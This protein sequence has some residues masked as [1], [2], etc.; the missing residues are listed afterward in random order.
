MSA[1]LHKVGRWCAEHA[2]RVVAAW[3][4]LIAALAGV[5]ALTGANLS[6]TFTINNAESM[7][8]LEVLENRLPQAAGTSEQVLFTAK[9]GDIEAHRQAIEGFVSAVSAMDGVAMVSQPF[10]SAAD[11]ASGTPASPSTVSQDGAHALA[12]IQA[13]TSL[14]S[15]TSGTTSAAQRLDAQIEEAKAAAQKA[16]PQLRIQDSGSIGASVSLG[17]SVVELIGVVIAAIVLFITFGSVLAAGAPLI[18]A[19]IGVAAGMLGIFVVAN[20]VDVNST[21]PVLAVMI[22]LAVGIDYA[23]F[24]ISRAREY[25]AQGLSPAEAAGCATATAGSAVVFAGTTVVIALCGLAVARIPF[26]TVMGVASAFVV[27]CAVLV[28]LTVVPALI[29]ALGRRLQ[30]DARRARCQRERQ[31]S[32]RPTFAQRW[33]RGVTRHPWLTVSAVLA[34]L[35]VAAVPITGLKLAL[36]DNGF[37]PE[38]TE[39][40]ET[41]DA[42]AAAYGDGYN[43]P[44][45]VIADITNTTDPLGVVDTLAKHISQIDGVADIAMATPNEDATLALVQIRPTYAQTDS[46]TEAV[47]HT[48]RD[49]ASTYEK[50]LGITEVMVTGQTAVAIDVSQSLNSALLPF[51]I[52]VVGL[53]L[54]LL[55]LVFRSIAVPLTATLGYL[56]SL[57]AGMGVAGAVFGWGWLAGLLDVSKVGA[58]ISFMPVI[59]M[60]VLFGLAMDYEVFLVSRMREEWIHRGGPV[61]RG[62]RARQI[63]CECVEKGFVGSATVVTAA[64]VIMTAVFAGFIPAELVEIKPIAVALTVGIAVDAFIVRMTL[65]PAIM[66]ALGPAAWRLPRWLERQLPVIDVEGEG[67]ERTLEHEAWVAEHGE[68]VLRAQGVTVSDSEGAALS[69]LDLTVAAGE[70]ALVRTEHSVARRALAALVGGRLRPSEGLLV[71]DDHVLPDGAAAIQ[72]VTT[73]IHAYDDPVAEHVK[74]V[75]VDDP[76]D[77]RWKRVGELA[78]RGVAV[79]VTAGPGAPQ[80]VPAASGVT[81]ASVVEVDGDGVARLRRAPQRVAAPPRTASPQAGR[82]A[83]PPPTRPASDTDHSDHTAGNEAHA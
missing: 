63:A 20:V 38:G 62:E 4:V 67:L 74:I 51:G 47:V 78:G 79:I 69:G 42:I 68:V 35:A 2:A 13:D 6:S 53:S 9:D 65:I 24:I 23:L 28:A 43:S 70:V 5:V 22:G 75:V 80:E 76:G 7:K 49:N 31:A 21:T 81:L 59:V 64:A 30:P 37:Q 25:L 83:T 48:I 41:Y 33:V 36:T 19:F 34:V 8:G 32:G 77:R 40:R 52:V 50:D 14:G 16:D 60:G 56:L 46:R 10:G 11:A 44:I 71:V 39:Q 29:G 45:V 1:L 73:S 58:V 55:M 66:S 17:L 26:L 18:A 72:T 61:A 15:I 27:A 12:Q 3:L 54:V 57:A 82:S